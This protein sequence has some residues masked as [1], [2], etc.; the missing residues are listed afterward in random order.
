MMMMGTQFGLVGGVMLIP[1]I[2]NS[3]THGSNQQ[4]IFS[5]T[6]KIVLRRLH[7]DLMKVFDLF[8]SCYPCLVDDF[9]AFCSR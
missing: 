7:P 3:W 2:V 1:E 4:N 6:K 5:N 9:Y 8:F